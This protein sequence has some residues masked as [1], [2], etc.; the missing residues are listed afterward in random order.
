MRRLVHM[1]LTVEEEMRP[2]ATE[3]LENSMFEKIDREG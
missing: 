2:S 1:C 3:L